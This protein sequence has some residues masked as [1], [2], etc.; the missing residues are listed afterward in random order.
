MAT[1][2]VVIATWVANPGEAEH[3]RALLE[4]MTP[5][6]RAEPKVICY[7]AHVSADDPNTFVLYEH[8]T[9]PSGYEEHRATEA[10]RSLVLNE[11][12]PRLASR[13][14]QTFTTIGPDT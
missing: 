14:V 1:G 2:F 6:S 7:Q 8:Y 10:F 4:K 3:I 12:I 5:L 9:D 13:T 11:A